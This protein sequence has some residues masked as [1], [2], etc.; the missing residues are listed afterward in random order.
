MIPKEYEYLMWQYCKDPNDIDKAIEEGD[1]NWEGLKSL[2]QI[3]S[4]TYDSNFG[5]YVVFWIAVY[6]EDEE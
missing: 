6:R 3:I 5:C 4:I 2:H 1:P